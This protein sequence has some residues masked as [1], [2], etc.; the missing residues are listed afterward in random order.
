[1]E[2]RRLTPPNTSVTSEYAI[3]S[4]TGHLTILS[5][6]HHK[7]PKRTSSPFRRVK[8]DAGDNLKP[9]FSD[10][11]FEAK[12]GKDQWGHRANETL[13][14]VKGKDF[15]REKGKKK[16]GGYKGGPIST[17]VNSIKF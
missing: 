15:R 5:N 9:G 12:H 7:Q 13:S 17:E 14:Q 8:S 1:M 2:K 16:R 10:N 6:S 3:E 4:E 11:S